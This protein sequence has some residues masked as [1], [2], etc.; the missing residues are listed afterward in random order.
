MDLSKSIL[1]AQYNNV[2]TSPMELAN[3][4][5]SGQFNTNYPLSS[6]WPAGTFKPDTSSYVKKTNNRNIEPGQIGSNWDLSSAMP[7]G[8]RVNDKFEYNEKHNYTLKGDPYQKFVL[9]ANHQ[10]PTALNTMFFHRINVHHIQKRILDEV[11]NITGIRVKP[12]SENS[13][14]IIMNNK[15]QYMLYGG[16]PVSPVHLSLPRGNNK[17]CSLEMRIK[18]LNQAV[19][20]EAVKQVLSGM[21]M[22]ADYYKHASSLPMPL[23][24]P[25][26]VSHKGDRV[27]SQNIGFSSGNS[28]GI[29]SFNMRNTIIN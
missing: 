11:E 10:V 21:N 27:L 7:V 5:G 17:P 4:R 14:L 9:D 15:Y 2:A 6:N 18:K 28:Q 26:Y 29:S 25:T 22:Y 13:I 12:Q 8:K 24:L 20:Q 19:I 23:E 16:L 1:S 3:T